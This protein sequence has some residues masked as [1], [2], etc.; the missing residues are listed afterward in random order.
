M[1]NP[2]W[3][4]TSATSSLSALAEEQLVSVFVRFM[5]SS[6]HGSNP[7]CSFDLN[8]P[9]PH[10]PSSDVL[11]E[12][13]A[14]LLYHQVTNAL[15]YLGVFSN[16]HKLTAADQRVAMKLWPQ[17]S[18]RQDGKS[19]F[20]DFVR[21]ISALLMTG[22]V[23]TDSSR[24]H[25][26]KRHAERLPAHHSQTLDHFHQ[27]PSLLNH[28]SPVNTAGPIS[29]RLSP[30]RSS[31]IQGN[32]YLTC[33]DL[34]DASMVVNI[35]A[36]AQSQHQNRELQRLVAS[37][38]DARRAAEEMEYQSRHLK[39]E[40][41]SL[42]DKLS[43]EESRRREAEA[44]ADDARTRL[45]SANAHDRDDIARAASAIEEA[46]KL[47]RNAQ[48][49]DS[50]HKRE[51]QRLQDELEAQQKRFEELQRDAGLA[52]VAEQ[53]TFQSLQGTARH[54][55][56]SRASR[57][58]AG[59]SDHDSRLQIEIE[60]LKTE[61]TLA[62]TKLRQEAVRV[63]ALTAAAALAKRESDSLQGQLRH[64]EKQRTPGAQTSALHPMLVADESSASA[65]VVR[66]REEL[67]DVKLALQA[68]RTDSP[69]LGLHEVDRQRDEVRRLLSQHATQASD[70]QRVLDTRDRELADLRVALRHVKD[71]LADT[72]ARHER[73]MED[74]RSAYERLR[75]GGNS[76]V[77]AFEFE[78]LKSQGK[79]L[80]EQLDSRDSE[81][82][83]SRTAYERLLAERRSASPVA[84]T[85]EL[86]GL[87]EQVRILRGNEANHDARARE[88]RVATAE[89][90]R[91]KEQQRSQ[92][93]ELR[94]SRAA[95]ERLLA[96]RRSASPV[97]DTSEL[98]RLREQVRILRGNEADH[99]SRARDLRVANAECDRL[100]EQL[101]S[102]DRELRDSRAAERRSA[103]P[104]VDTSE[105]ERLREQ[106][107]ILRG[108]E[109]DHDSRAREL[110]VANAECD[111]LKGQLKSQ[112]R[113]LRDSRAA[114][115]RLLAERRSASPGH[116]TSDLE[117]LREQVRILR[118][119]EADHDSRSRELRV[120]TA[121]C[122]R[123]KE[124]LV[125]L[126]ARS[127]SRDLELAALR[128]AYESSLGE[129]A[130]NDRELTDLKAAYSR[131]LSE[132]TTR[133]DAQELERLREQLRSR[134]KAM[135]GV[136]RE[137]GG[138]K[139]AYAL[140][141]SEVAES[142]RLRALV[143][144]LRASV[145]ARD[146]E[147]ADLRAAY[148]RLQAQEES[149]PRADYEEINRLRE[150]I[151]RLQDRLAE[152]EAC[153]SELS[154]LRAEI[155]RLNAHLRDA[156]DELEAREREC[157]DLRQ[158][159][160]RLQTQN[161][162][163]T[164]EVERLRSQMQSLRKSLAD[165][166]EQ[167]RADRREI[168]HLR[169]ELAQLDA[170][171]RELADARN[172]LRAAQ[173]REEEDKAEI[174]RLQTRLRDLAEELATSKTRVEEL[175]AR[176]RALVLKEEEAQ[177]EIARL[178]EQVRKHEQ[179]I[180]I[181]E[182]RVR[183]LEER[184]RK[185]AVDYA[186]IERLR[187]Q[188]R[189]L[190]DQLA[191][192]ER[193]LRETYSLKSS[194]T[195]VKI[196]TKSP[197]I[198]TKVTTKPVVVAS[199]QEAVEV[200]KPRSPPPS[201]PLVPTQL[202]C[203]RPEDP[204]WDMYNTLDVKRM[205]GCPPGNLSDGGAFETLLGSLDPNASPM[206]SAPVCQSHVCYSVPGSRQLMQPPTTQMSSSSQLLATSPRNKWSRQQQ[207]RQISRRMT[208]AP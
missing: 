160:E 110:R 56:E 54:A 172:A 60:R 43:H 87:R 11:V 30:P 63:S 150:Q 44:F 4:S 24:K 59:S 181:L 106:V 58:L 102:Q 164:D 82:R 130:A 208:A 199:V 29:C 17:L 112:D 6:D 137:L 55:E 15:A 184:L 161:A 194:S 180:A 195:S 5:N 74:L 81:L 136:E 19:Y 89:C 103:S 105:L 35:D 175:E 118:G 94:D 190:Q 92:D 146:R 7:A 97:V 16:P 100:K 21:V 158:A 47:R 159:T 206:C 83:D 192:A 62:E 98:E 48:E 134:Q 139:T 77:D 147:L 45:A 117:R 169:A 38:R 51:V 34:G 183:E 127:D 156:K 121:E 140:L 78:R 166:G 191:A 79:S 152:S 167:S 65:E 138:L 125:V 76:R 84:D 154:K 188:L 1:N 187:V 201:R 10:P 69:V 133:V 124:Q 28:A 155:D 52:R 31:P 49:V 135:E 170:L 185:E 129:K 114:C 33:V 46:T 40:V 8:P 141:Q 168:D 14:K 128:A 122:D 39:D 145:D 131:L 90:D 157:V 67:S 32:Q 198:E 179:Q 22:K 85:L 70:H 165:M 3:D 23:P 41:H 123:L 151:R 9:I 61:L 95:C 75:S 91:L 18:P 42:Q 113:E 116:D 50:L 196:I 149:P 99:D 193:K 109:A 101:K 148:N 68:Q 177:A 20:S 27:T 115:E 88:L 203:T 37:E 119:N 205:L 153:A 132:Q 96:E 182:T 111:R 126:Q 66:L 107:R 171:E 204:V 200:V 25:R 189:L 64:L 36:E 86:E 143:A 186:E 202:A 142:E 13:G 207:Y 26:K 173:Q 73:E 104:V 93:R 53:Q 120:A 57:D 163:L 144:E 2:I 162:S 71:Q 174:Q 12:S 197:T 178:C 72:V 108:N 80:R 176:V